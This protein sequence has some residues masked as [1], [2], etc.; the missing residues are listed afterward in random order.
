MAPVGTY[1][2]PAKD[3]LDPPLSLN[4]VPVGICRSPKR[5]I[6]AVGPPIG[7]VKLTIALPFI[8]TVAQSLPVLEVK[9][10]VTP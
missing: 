6:P 5:T 2:A 9:T 10:K 1:T 4:A 3:W 7:A 8:V